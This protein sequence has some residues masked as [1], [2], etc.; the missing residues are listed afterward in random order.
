[1][2]RSSERLDDRQRTKEINNI[3]QNRNVD[4]YIFLLQQ[5]DTQDETVTDVLLY[6]ADYYIYY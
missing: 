1:M 4:I 3:P 5:Q 2:W 6:K